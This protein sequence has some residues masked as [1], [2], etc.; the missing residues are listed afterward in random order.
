VRIDSCTPQERPSTSRE[1][2]RGPPRFGPVERRTESRNAGLIA[3]SVP[4][5]A[6]H[7]CEIAWEFGR[8]PIQTVMYHK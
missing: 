8:S 4:P 6:S 7:E 2:R 1:F 3:A 5:S